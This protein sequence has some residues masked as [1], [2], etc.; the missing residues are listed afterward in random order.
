MQPS[1][2]PAIHGTR[3]AAAIMVGETMSDHNT[4]RNYS[5][6]INTVEAA[7]ALAEQDVL[8]EDAMAGIVSNASVG[9]SLT[10]MAKDHRHSRPAASEEVGKANLTKNQ[11]LMLRGRSGCRSAVEPTTKQSSL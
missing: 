5:K 4:I 9:E 10:A 7:A 1:G 11:V 8:S 6:S 3:A 2:G